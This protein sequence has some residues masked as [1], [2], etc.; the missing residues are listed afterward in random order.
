[1]PVS[2]TEGRPTSISLSPTIADGI[3]VGKPGRLNFDIVR[4]LV[5]EVVTVDDDAT[6][7]ALLVLL[8]RAKLVVEPAGA[9]GVAAVQSG[10]V[11]PNG[12]TVIVLSGG[13]IDP[14]VMERIVSHGLA[15][16]GR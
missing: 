14:L 13:N 12:P 2:L 5:D 6:A 3:A 9:V 10:L 8:E 15:A 4:D 11:Q 1:F 16:S 7:K